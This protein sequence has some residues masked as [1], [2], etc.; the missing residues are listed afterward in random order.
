[1]KMPFTRYV[2]GIFAVS[3]WAPLWW[4]IL[5]PRYWQGGELFTSF[6]YAQHHMI[7]PMLVVWL[8]VIPLSISG[9]LL[10]FKFKRGGRLFTVGCPL[11]VMGIVIAQSVGLVNLVKLHY[12][13]RLF[14]GRMS[15]V[16]WHGIV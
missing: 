2:A 10:A 1:M 6:Y 9:C 4:A 11:V 8:G 14:A 3:L 16:R 13:S 7:Y 5:L 12:S 15:V